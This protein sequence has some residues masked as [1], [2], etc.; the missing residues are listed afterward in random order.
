MSTSTSPSQPSLFAK[1]EQEILE[2]WKKEHVFERSIEERPDTK[3]Y[4]FYDGPPFATGL[5]HYGHLLQSAIKDAV[6]RYWTMNGYRVP[7]RWGWDCHGLPIENLI[8]KELKLGSKRDIERFGIEP[9]TAACRASVFTYENE[10]EKYVER[11][12][13][14]VDFKRSY[15]TMDNDYIE[16]VWWVFFELYKK[17][18]VYKNVRV[19]LYCPRC[20][21][22]L[23]NFEVAMGNSYI[24]HEDPAIYVKFPVVG[25]EKTFFVAWTTTPWSI[26]GITGL[27]V[28]QDLMYVAAKI[29]STGETLIFA[30]ARQ[31][32][33]LRLHVLPTT[34]GELEGVSKEEGGSFQ[35]ISRWLGKD[36]VGKYVE[37]P[38]HFLPVEGDAYRVVLGDHVTAETGTGVVTTA[39]AFGE[40]DLVTARKQNL[41]LLFTL[42]E[43]GRMVKECGAFAGLK[44][45]EADVSIMQD[46]RD[47]GLLY[48][49]ERITHSVPI[50]YRCS[51]LLLYKAQPAWFIDI[52]KLK[53]S[54]LKTAK[55]ISWHPDH[56]KEGRFG[57]G[58]ASAPDWN[59]SRSRYWGSPIPVWECA[60]CGKRTVVGSVA[61][62]TKLAKEGHVTKGMDLHRPGIDAI[63]IPCACGQE[64]SRIPEVFDCWLESG[65]MPFASLHY[66]FENKKWFE[67]NFPADFIGEAQDQ[68]RGWFYTLHVLSTALFEKPA[69]KHAI[70]TGLIL[71]EDGRKM[72]KSLKNYPDP[73]KVF[74]A[75]GADALRYYLFSSPVLEADSLNF[76]ERDLQ[77]IV[78]GFLNLVWN[79]KVFYET[80]AP[81]RLALTKPRSVHVLDRWLF[82]RLTELTQEMTKQMNAYEL[83]RATRPLRD[84]VDDLSTWWLRRSRERIKAE[85]E[86]EKVDALRTLR[87]VLEELAKLMA[88]FTPFL[89][90]KIYQDIGGQ[91]MSV[92]LERWPKTEARF[93]DP[94][95]TS[96]MAWVR[97]VA[98]RTHELRTEA[99]LAV[100]QVLAS[101][102]ISLRESAEVSRLMQQKD[103][104]ALL[105][106]EVNVEEI[107]VVVGTF[108][109]EVSWQAALDTV[110]TPALR[111][112]GTRREFTRHVMHARKEAGLRPIDRVELQVVL[113]LGEMRMSLETDLASLAHDVR[114]VKVVF[115]D[116]LPMATLVTQ[117]VEIAG[118]PMQL[119]LIKV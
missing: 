71:A 92:H 15:K 69:F 90:E 9:F 112:K 97:A 13:R 3:G 104:L 28:H 66:P 30:E 24:D 67:D 96:D 119:A 55:K 98:S 47:R 62:L 83:M 86:F 91:K 33:V 87:E 111:Q 7:R 44:A 85:N 80:Y 25:E 40:D 115:V 27:A 57:K 84:F 16:S 106:E 43:E 74:D 34:K 88:P 26:P 20:A 103:L 73:W 72:S 100:R 56:F 64:Q 46:L 48:R 101:L 29:A 11:L 21:T 89:A 95:L 45:K 32:D 1:I 36:L 79:V 82:S 50:C 99:K 110:I 61:E 93:I 38:Y 58:L 4:V 31:S 113:A 109:G 117:A 41:P 53:P 118:E 39:P 6:P 114:A 60:D 70:V 37:T 14:W 35:I 22:P 81:H 19:S 59:I 65:S 18:Y 10:W 75:Y 107:R 2:F 12:G 49:E 102:T 54:L 42:D 63:K 116:V 5:P 77:S 76:S 51:T 105:R 52:T 94:R 8:E 17:D 108:E 23:S 78:R 68:T